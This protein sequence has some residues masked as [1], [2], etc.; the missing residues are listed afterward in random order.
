M[1]ITCKNITD[2]ENILIVL[3][4]IYL[5]ELLCVLYLKNKTCYKKLHK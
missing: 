1:K 3:K 5:C 2:R 4:I